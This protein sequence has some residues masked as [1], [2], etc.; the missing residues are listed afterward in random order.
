MTL[1]SHGRVPVSP[2]LQ[3]AGHPEVFV[4]GDLAEIPGG[5]DPLPMLAQVAIQSG[6]RARA[7]SAMRPAH[8]K[9]AYSRQAR[10]IP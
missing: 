1:A 10:A 5:D 6:R 4:V 3:L 7:T 9:P 8:Q 2:T